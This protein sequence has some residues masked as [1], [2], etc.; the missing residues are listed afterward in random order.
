MLRTERHWPER[1]RI[2]RAHEQ[3]S[4][5][6]F[7]YTFRAGTESCGSA[8][9]GFGRKR[10]CAVAPGERTPVSLHK[11]TGPASTI[12]SSWTSHTPAENTLPRVPAWK[13]S[14]LTSYVA[15]SG[16]I[17]REARRDAKLLRFL[18]EGCFLCC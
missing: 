5:P 13:R 15:K 3:A 4:G 7:A 10:A 12:E 8:V 2:G 18:R 17:M 9:A 6:G 16:F 1:L 11:P 14:K